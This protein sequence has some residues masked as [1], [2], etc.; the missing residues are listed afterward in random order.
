MRQNVPWS[1]EGL[2]LDTREAAKEAARR[3]GMSV[4]EW[5]AAT[6][7]DR[8]AR[9]GEAA[10]PRRRTATPAAPTPDD[11]DHVASRLNKI[12]RGKGAASRDLEAIMA[13]ASAETDR[14]ARDSAAKTAVALDSV[15][16]WIERAEDRFSETSRFVSERQDRTTAILGEALGLMTRRLD[17]IERKVV[18]GQQPSMAL[19]MKALEKVETH[20]ARMNEASRDTGQSAQV[21][22]ALKAFESR[23][24]GL[25]ERITANRP[26][27][28]RGVAPRD[29][30]LEAVA[31]IRSRQAE[32]EAGPVAV[33]RESP[34]LAEI[35]SHTRSHAEI[36]H[37]L[38]GDIARLAG[39]L[40]SVRVPDPT[41]SVVAAMRGEME[42]IHQSL[43]GLATRRE[44]AALEGVMGE[45]HHRIGAVRHADPVTI[46]L[47]SVTAP[48][49][50]LQAEVQRLSEVVAAGVH[51]RI[52]GDIENLARKVDVVAGA[53]V[54]PE[55][56]EALSRQLADVRRV[57]GE[58]AEPQRVQGLAEQMGDLSR[59]VAQVARNQV[60]AL[61]FAS[62]K[63]TVD[64]IRAVIKMPRAGKDGP[65]IL[66]AI[67]TLTKKLDTL[68]Q[69][70]PSGDLSGVEQ[71]LKSLSE[72]IVSDR[73]PT[74]E[75]LA[76]LDDLTAR[77]QPPSAPENY[78]ERFDEI[79]QKLASR[80]DPAPEI[81]SRLDDLAAR[82]E[83][84][85]G[86]APAYEPLAR[87][88]IR[89]LEDMLRQ[90]AG[91][92]DATPSQGA[93]PDT[94]D[95]LERQ[96]REIADRLDRTPSSDPALATLERGM[97]ELMAQMESFR[98]I[99]ASAQPGPL[100]EL[101]AVSR[102]LADLRAHYSQTDK[103]NRDTL[104]AVHGSLEKLVQ[105]LASLEQEPPARRAPARPAAPPPAPPRAEP[106][107]EAP[108]I[109]PET[110]GYES[111]LPSA[112][113]VD[114]DLARRVAALTQ[115][116]DRP[117]PPPPPSRTPE[118]LIEPGAGRP[119]GD[120]G[121]DAD[122]DAGDI[123]ASFIAAARRAAQAAATEAAAASQTRPGAERARR[124]RSSLA[125]AAL[126][127]RMR[128]TF[129][130][131]R[132]PLVIGLAAIVLAIGAIQVGGSLFGGASKPTPVAQNSAPDIERPA[133]AAP[134]PAIP[135]AGAAASIVSPETTQSIPQRGFRHPLAPDT[136][137]P[138]PTPQSRATVAP[139]PEAL[140]LAPVPE[141]PRPSEVIASA[142]G[143]I[144]TGALP[145]APRSPQRATIIANIGDIPA[146]IGP[147]PLRKA[148]MAG[149]P[150][151]V[152]ELASRAADG[153]GMNRDPKLAARLFERAAANGSAPAQYRIGSHYEKGLGVTRDL[154][155]AKLWYQ[156]AAEKGNA[157]A[158]HNLAVLLAEGAGEKPDY[159]GAVDWFRRAA[160]HGVRDSQYNLAVLLAR[161]LGTRQD[162]SGAFTWFSVAA[163][164]GDTDAGKKRDEVASRLNATELTS[165]KTAAE[166]W[167][168]EIPDRDA[169]EA[170][171][172]STAWL[173]STG[174][175]SQKSAQKI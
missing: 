163:G 61:D 102:E 120:M 121:G 49:E 166:R 3:S 76:R 157:R 66:R 79:A 8:A 106:R 23:I 94:L 149:D 5:V 38:K 35:A 58:I 11:L 46:D 152:F 170:P 15:A 173:D 161:G 89:P 108:Q 104:E 51:T 129:E 17:D 33:R 117:L 113:A 81:L 20:V 71:H 137:T 95:A 29:E 128:K 119:R 146:S 12:T 164:Q 43:R 28:R 83:T 74:A 87:D 156:R 77:I 41:A 9:Y 126:A 116:A 16:R 134:A 18:E 53:G 115:D 21:E 123:K 172:P 54:A 93:A 55:V 70:I 37:S 159:I 110:R 109:R 142:T 56:V 107:H 52:V 141:T 85:R 150:A 136:P 168:P 92:L 59:Q 63:N 84:P 7:A 32:I 169:N 143:E 114:P 130:K 124:A 162:L 135:P 78:G 1:L 4:D 40:D 27:G 148:A 60:D 19:A 153:R 73:T 30:I 91:R 144:A 132:R 154:A 80:N 82:L 31:E 112:D 67:D 96:V 118:V 171:V 75:I 151:A 174:K 90:L 2:D 62:L 6:I 97:S 50:E 69:R 140:S 68:E 111:A 42:D 72:Q 65:E 165:A 122:I 10:T 167:R 103:R 145:E 34:A 155:L 64:D 101:D 160:E 127:E 25:T 158:M 36:L 47:R 125:P 39:Q 45:L 131:R 13:V 175:A 100:P 26:L 105:R 147:A 22:A 86:V 24:A 133:A 57:V 14:R 99:G 138:P 139:A 98:D 44:V 88:D 48:I